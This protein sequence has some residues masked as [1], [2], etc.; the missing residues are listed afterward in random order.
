[1]IWQHY[2][3]VLLTTV[4]TGEVLV[5]TENVAHP[6]TGP[7]CGM[8]TVVEKSRSMDGTYA[9]DKATTRREIARIA[10][11]LA[12]EDSVVFI[13]CGHSPSL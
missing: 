5:L 7:P 6:W 10:F 2:G 12:S 13:E 9:K 11:R 1:M 3:H 4:N 8:V